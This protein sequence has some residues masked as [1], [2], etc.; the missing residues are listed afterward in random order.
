MIISYVIEYIISK[1]FLLLLNITNDETL[2]IPVYKISFAF[3]S[4]IIWY[5]IYILC[6][7]KNINIT[8]L[9]KMN[10]KTK[11]LLIINS[12]FMVISFALQ[13]FIFSY[14]IDNLPV[15]ITLIFI[16]VLLGYY[17][18]LVLG[19]NL[20]LIFLRYLKLNQKLF[21]DF[22]VLLDLYYLIDF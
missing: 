3:I 15:Y 2:L 9:D 14:Y 17:I 16:I 6:N 19:L 22:S 5:S 11:T 21:F 10:N 18:L 20:F 7:K 1:F 13:T 4:Y 8:I 12:I